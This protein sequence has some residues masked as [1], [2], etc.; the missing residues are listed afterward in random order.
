MHPLPIQY[1]NL[2][3]VKSHSNEVAEDMEVKKKNSWHIYF[4]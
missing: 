2:D 4:S 3:T 1:M